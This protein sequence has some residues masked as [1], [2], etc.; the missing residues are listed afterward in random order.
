MLNRIAAVV[1]LVLGS[2]TMAF[3]STPPSVPEPGILGLLATGAGSA[4]LFY[5]NRRQGK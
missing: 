4:L 2:A 5:R 3:A 1:L